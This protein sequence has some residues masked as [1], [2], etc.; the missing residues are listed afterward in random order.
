MRHGLDITYLGQSKKTGVSEY[1]GGVVHYTIALS[2]ADYSKKIIA[3]FIRKINDAVF[4]KRHIAETEYVISLEE[5]AL[6]F[7]LRSLKAMCALRDAIEEQMPDETPT[8]YSILCPISLRIPRDPY[9]IRTSP[10]QARYEKTEL[11]KALSLR[12]MD[13]MTG[14]TLQSSEIC[15]DNVA[16]KHNRKTHPFS[17]ADT[18]ADYQNAISTT[19]ITETQIATQTFHQHE[20]RKQSAY[21]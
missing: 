18:I 8:D 9:Y 12:A 1:I 17:L 7:Q 20:R 15:P 14:L 2:Q 11:E 5:K 19:H 10:T 16:K 21:C 3:D 6:Q 13:P 4:K